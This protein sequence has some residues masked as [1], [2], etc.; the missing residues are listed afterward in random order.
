[1]GMRVIKITKNSSYYIGTGLKKTN[2]KIKYREKKSNE[3][4]KNIET[5]CMIRFSNLYQS[6]HFIY[7]SVFGDIILQKSYT[8]NLKFYGIIIGLKNYLACY[9]NGLVISKKTVLHFRLFNNN[10]LISLLNIG[11][12]SSTKD[13]KI[14]SS[15]KGI[16]NDLVYKS[17][18]LN[19]LNNYSKKILPGSNTF[20]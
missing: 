8:F 17:V 3:N 13:N 18:H 20:Y 4:S 12:K 1:M 5:F 7:N 2:Y 11:Y 19:S 6:I 16:L 9:F 14:Y 15:I 10:S